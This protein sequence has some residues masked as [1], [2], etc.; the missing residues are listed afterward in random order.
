MPELLGKP[1]PC[2]LCKA[3]WMVTGPL[4]SMPSTGGERANADSS[5]SRNRASHPGDLPAVH[6]SQDSAAVLGVRS[7]PRTL[8]ALQRSVGNAAV[9]LRFGSNHG[10]TISLQRE[11]V[12]TPASQATA[13]DRK[14]AQD[15]INAWLQKANATILD[16]CMWLSNN[17]GKYLTVTSLSPEL[18]WTD[19]M[20]FKAATGLAGGKIRN[21]G[22]AAAGALM[23]VEVGSTAGPPGAIIGFLVGLAVGKIT[24]IITAEL[25]GSAAKSSRAAIVTG[26]AITA[27]NN[28]F[29]AQAKEMQSRAALEFNAVQTRLNDETDSRAVYRIYEW[30]SK[31]MANFTSPTE[32]DLSLFESM[33]ADWVLEHAGIT[34][35]GE[36][37]DPA[38]WAAGVKDAKNLKGAGVRGRPNLFGYQTRGH[39]AAA[40]LPKATAQALINGAQG[41][42]EAGKMG[43]LYD[44]WAGKKIVFNDVDDVDKFMTFMARY[45]HVDPGNRADI[46]NGKITVS[47][48]LGVAILP[49]D[50]LTIMYWDY[51]VTMPDRKLHT[52][53]DPADAGLEPVEFGSGKPMSQSF[54]VKP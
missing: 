35:A 18:S 37:T 45:G 25:S 43:G 4:R 9:A 36:G 19:S 52:S 13:A 32:G 8:L 14:I 26:G 21:V 34:G 23:G 53:T 30:A 46:Q 27:S 41:P 47:C 44:E 12:S 1:G 40:G 28:R 50:S 33:Y 15:A 54:S 24:S 39:W 42:V 38:Q 7:S 3:G 31:E 17:Y 6:L 20:L 16:F 11:P 2:D 10:S 22:T 29:F 5:S 48:K 51:V 49:P